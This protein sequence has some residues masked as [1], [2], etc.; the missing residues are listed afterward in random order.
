MEEARFE[1]CVPGYHVY[2]EIWEAVLG[3]TLSC[4]REPTNVSDHYAVAVLKD[5][6]QSGICQGSSV[7]WTHKTEQRLSK[8]FIGPN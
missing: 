7:G 2:S 3:E 6:L 5:D 4:R 8:I 1:C